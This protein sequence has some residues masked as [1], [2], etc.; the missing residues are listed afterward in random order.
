MRSS[1]S[2]FQLAVTEVGL[3]AVI[4]EHGYCVIGFAV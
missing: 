2:V 1:V 4:I 3:R